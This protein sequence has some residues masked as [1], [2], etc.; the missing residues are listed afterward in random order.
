MNTDLVTIEV[1]NGIADV[2]LNRA[3]KYNA[4][5]HDMFD[6][7]IAAGQS[8]ANASDVSAVVLSGNGRGFCAGLDMAN[9][10][11][12]SDGSRQSQADTSSLL[13]KDGHSEAISLNQG[14]TIGI[15]RKQNEA[16]SSFPRY[17]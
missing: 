11:S 8:L 13:A 15:Q 10:A 14:N 7:I 6:A 12:M 9:F 16:W 1:S 17:G 4:L 5:S 3:E 2:R